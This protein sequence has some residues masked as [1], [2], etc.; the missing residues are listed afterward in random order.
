MQRNALIV[1]ALALL[2]I[3]NSAQAE[4]PAWNQG[5]ADPAAGI[6]KPAPLPNGTKVVLDRSENNKNDLNITV[7]NAS[8]E[9]FTVRINGSCEMRYA[10]ETMFYEA[11]NITCGS[12]LSRKF[13]NFS[14]SLW[15]LK[16]GNEISFDVAGH[17]GRRGDS[18]QNRATCKVA[19]YGSFDIVAGSVDAFK[20]ECRD[21]TVS[22][23]ALYAPGLGMQA[24]FDARHR[25]GYRAYFEVESVQQP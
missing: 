1:V 4:Q 24:M 13:S 11:S 20:V 14:G 16:V 3:S 12:D 18:W 25:N 15:P 9:G 2:T 5:L 7:E 19:E 21:A 6:A 23:T 17:N 8:Q 10:F 22:T